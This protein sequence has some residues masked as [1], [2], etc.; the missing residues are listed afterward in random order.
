MTTT[1][2]GDRITVNKD[3][4]VCRE[5]HGLTATIIDSKVEKDYKRRGKSNRVMLVGKHNEHLCRFDNP[6]KTT[7]SCKALWLREDMFTEN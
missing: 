5:Y 4:R 6:P 3:G 1:A 7:N 2:K